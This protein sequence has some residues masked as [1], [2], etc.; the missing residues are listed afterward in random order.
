MQVARADG[1][2]VTDLKGDSGR[3]EFTRLDEGLPLNAETFFALK[4]RF[5]P[6]PSGLKRYVLAVTGLAEGRYAVSAEGRKLGTWTARQLADGVNIASSTS[7]PWQPGGPWD[8]QANVV[9]TLTESRDRLDLAGRLAAN[10]FGDG[11]LPKEIDPQMRD[12]NERIE[13][14]QRE[15]AR[16][17]PYRFV[18]EPAA[19]ESRPD[20]KAK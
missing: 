7:D 2:R 14:L 4:F 20:A 6:I 13:A 3:F 19:E 11:P 8:A 15:I 16:P 1:C 17:R 18:I 9:A 5:V 12:A 10:H